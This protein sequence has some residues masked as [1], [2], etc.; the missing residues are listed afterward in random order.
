MAP[1]VF[2]GVTLP[3]LRGGWLC[4]DFAN[5]VDYDN[6]PGEEDYLISY[7][8]LARWAQYVGILTGEQAERLLRIAEA[9]P[10]EATAVLQRALALREA[11]TTIFN[12]I[13]EHGPV[14]QDALVVLNAEL[15]HAMA[16]AGIHSTNEGFAW[17]WA[18]ANETPDRMLWAVARS[19]ADLLTSSSLDRVRRCPNETCGWLFLDTSK[20]GSRR[21]C[22]MDSCGNVMKQRRHQHKLRTTR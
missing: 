16:H 2:E 1:V 20:N 17:D 22:S 18:D 12:A 7:L 8:M 10:A 14:T 9:A 13:A 19:A 15:A 21:W 3:R 4:L 6:P 5:T 11:I